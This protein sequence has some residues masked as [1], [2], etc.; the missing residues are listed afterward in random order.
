MSSIFND[1]SRY[2]QF[3]VS[4]GLRK[5]ENP[6]AVKDYS[7]LQQI[8]RYVRTTLANGG[9]DKVIADSAEPK[10]NPG[11]TTRQEPLIFI[12]DLDDIMDRIDTAKHDVLMFFK[13]LFDHDPTWGV[14]YIKFPRKFAYLIKNLPA[15]E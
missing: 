5:R 8:R 1:H 2:N 6:D 7:E 9:M 10:Y 15:E 4:K 14:L 3:I 13:R 12:H 11:S